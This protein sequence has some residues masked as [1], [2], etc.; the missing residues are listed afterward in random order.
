MIKSRWPTLLLLCDILFSKFHKLLANQNAVFKSWLSLGLA[1][2]QAHMIAQKLLSYQNAAFRTIDDRVILSLVNMSAVAILD[3]CLLHDLKYTILVQQMRDLI[4]MYFI[5][6][7]QLPTCPRSG[8]FKVL[9]MIIIVIIDMITWYMLFSIIMRNF[10]KVTKILV[11]L[12]MGVKIT[13]ILN[14]H[15]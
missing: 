14:F 9:P 7:F 13:D 5:P 1:A 15:G 3:F 6:D 10:E 4:S 2:V 8:I 11:I 12:S